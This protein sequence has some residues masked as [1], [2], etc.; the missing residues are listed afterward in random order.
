[1]EELG[2]ASYGEDSAPILEA[3][4]TWLCSQRTH[5]R[6]TEG[7]FYFFY[8]LSFFSPTPANLPCIHVHMYVGTQWGDVHMCPCVYRCQTSLPGVIPQK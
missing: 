7:S 5:R 6:R 8:F 1:M 4:S 3:A 2:R